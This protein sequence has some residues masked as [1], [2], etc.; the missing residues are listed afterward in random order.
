MT[1]TS[2]PLR[3]ENESSKFHWLF[4][5]GGRESTNAYDRPIMETQ[6]FVVLPSLGSIVSGWLLIVPK[7]PIA[8]IADIAPEI[9]DEFEVLVAKVRS[10]VEKKYGQ[11]FL[12]E[13]GGLAGSSVSCGVDQA[14][15]HIVPLPFDL[16]AAALKT[17]AGRW[18]GCDSSVLPY[19][20]CGSEE[21][22]YV[23]SDRLTLKIAVTEPESQWFRKLIASE[24]GCSDSWDYKK[25]SFLENIQDTIEVMG[26]HG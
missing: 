21:Y 6:N 4:L 17:D 3:S 5:K 24:L 16:P 8:R 14:H 23:S 15:L 13:H 18:V 1:K 19:D 12:F 22:W 10:S 26:I 20:V 25:S 2:K 11:T 9:R 7:W